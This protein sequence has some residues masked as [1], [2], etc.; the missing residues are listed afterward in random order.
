MIV[1]GDSR[2]HRE[3]KGKKK[4]EREMD[5]PDR[6]TGC[7]SLRIQLGKSRNLLNTLNEHTLDETEHVRFDG[8]RRRPSDQ[9][10]QRLFFFAGH[11]SKDEIASLGNYSDCTLTS[12]AEWPET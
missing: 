10:V 3:P 4:R 1:S 12:H 9:R 8:P 7:V 5:R 2:W 6:Q 11:G